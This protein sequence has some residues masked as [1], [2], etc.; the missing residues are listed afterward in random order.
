ML[1]QPNLSLE[2][3]PLA[4]G[5]PWVGLEPWVEITSGTSTQWPRKESSATSC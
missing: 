3:F 2:A 1:R 5:L 4:G